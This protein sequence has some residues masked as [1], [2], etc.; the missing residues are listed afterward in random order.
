[1][2]YFWT[3]PRIYSL[4]ILILQYCTLDKVHE[5]AHCKVSVC[6]LRCKFVEKE[7]SVKADASVIYNF[8]V[9]NEERVL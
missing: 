7:I 2:H 8:D 5:K 6:I 4:M 3:A 1:M 9:L